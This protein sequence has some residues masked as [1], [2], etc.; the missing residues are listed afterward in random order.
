MKYVAAIGSLVW[1][2]V[3]T[4]TMA[5][6]ITF[7]MSDSLPAGHVIAE[8]ATKPW[9]EL[10]EKE[11]AGKIKIEYYP[12]EQLGKAKDFLQ[13]TQSGLIDIG[14]IGPS[15]VSEKMPLSA[16]AELPGASKNSCEVMQSY[17]KL[18]SPGGWLFENEFKPNG[19]HP[20]FVVAL[21]PYQLVLGK[22]SGGASSVDDLHNKKIRAAGGAQSLTMEALGM[23]PVR[24]SPPEIYDAMSR[25]TIDGA[26]LAHISIDSYKLS[27]ITSAVTVGENF[28]TIAVAYSMGERKWQSLSKEQ[29]DLFDKV[30]TE[31]VAKACEEFDRRET[32]AAAELEKNDIKLVMFSSED[33]S[34]LD[35]ANAQIGADWAQEIDS[36]G[37]P[38]SAAL[39][40][41][42]TALQNVRNK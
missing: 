35:S 1:M 4:A 36:R 30:G 33:Q 26:L 31:I 10:I 42:N 32:S 21:P 34:R 29:Q 38:G 5:Q 40:A 22:S 3:S 39:E 8:V 12:S 6:E 28:G 24:M 23:V 37:L 20:L 25:G 7:R 2:S 19:L 16:V 15:Y 9:I 11:A 27:G 41:F 18:V 14:Y 13:L 17:W